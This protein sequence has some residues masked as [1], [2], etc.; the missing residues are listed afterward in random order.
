MAECKEIM[1]TVIMILDIIVGGFTIYVGVNNIFH[2]IDWG[3]DFGLQESI[4][5]LFYGICLII[6][7]LIL[8]CVEV[9][10]K[11]PEIQKEFGLLT[12]YLGRGSYV[13]FLALLSYNSQSWYWGGKVIGWGATLGL[14]SAILC[15]IMHS[16]MDCK[17]RDC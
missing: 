2:F 3:L 17:G 9:N 1:K 7:G 4:N 11:K 14:I 16:C 12:H 15:V 13:F 5:F 10:V 6:L 8:I